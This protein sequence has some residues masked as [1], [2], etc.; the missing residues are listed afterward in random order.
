[1]NE[2]VK[3]QP[4]TDIIELPRVPKKD[5]KTIT[6]TIT[7]NEDKTIGKFNLLQ[8]NEHDYATT[9]LTVAPPRVPDFQEDAVANN[10]YSYDV[11]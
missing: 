4:S 6:G 5:I 2:S 9:P 8:M 7:R 1:M 3:N 10:D 11:T